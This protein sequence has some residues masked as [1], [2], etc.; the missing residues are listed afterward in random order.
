MVIHDSNSSALFIQ[1]TCGVI[2]HID[3]QDKDL[4]EKNKWQTTCPRPDLTYVSRRMRTKEGRKGIY[5]HRVIAER[6]IG[7]LL[8]RSEYV[9]HIDGNPLNNIRINLR[10][11]T[12]SQNCFNSKKPKNNTSGYKGVRRNHKRWMAV[13]KVNRKPIYLGT[14]DTPEQAHKAYCEAAERYAGEFARF[15]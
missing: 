7:R 6:M 3:E 8:R 5:L 10:I 11:S 2:V 15:E 12:G 1:L 9:D 13:I 14:Y 4:F